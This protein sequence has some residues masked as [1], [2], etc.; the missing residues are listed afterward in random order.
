M[1]PPVIS[2]SLP[3]QLFCLMLVCLANLECRVCNAQSVDLSGDWKIRLDPTDVGKNERWFESVVGVDGRLPGIVTEAGLGN[4]LQLQPELTQKVLEHLHQK[5]SYIGSAWFSRRFEIED[6]E[7]FANAMLYLERVLWTSEVWING[8]YIGKGVSLSVPHRF[9]LGRHLKQGGNLI[10]VRV[11]NR[12][13]VDIGVLGH[14]YTQQ[15]QTI[16][17]GI[18]GR[19]EIQPSN[20]VG[21]ERF[22]ALPRL[23]EGNQ[24]RLGLRLKNDAQ[25]AVSKWIS[26]EVRETLSGQL[27]GGTKHRLEIS[28]GNSEIF[29]NERLRDIKAWSEHSPTLYQ[30]TCD[31]DGV[32]S[33]LITGF[34]DVRSEGRQIKINGRWSFMRGTLDCCL[35]PKTGYPPSKV[36]DWHRIFSTLNSYGINHVR[37][38]SWCPPDAAFSAADQLGLYLQVELPNWTSR[39]GKEPRVDRF[40]RSEGLRILAEY[41][42]H[43][44]FMFLSLGNELAGD[45]A[46][47]DQLVSDLRIVAPHLLFTSTSFSFTKRGKQPGPDDDYFITQQTPTGWVRGQRSLELHPPNTSFDYSVGLSSV[48]LPLIAHEVGQYC[49]FP[50]LNQIRKIDGN[51]MALGLQAIQRDLKS[52]G[53]G[54]LADKL[55][56]NSGKLA[57]IL[58]KEEIERALRTKELSGFQLLGLQD[59]LGQSTASVGLLDAFWESKGI[60]NSARFREFCSPTVPLLRMP[61]RCWT[62]GETFC[63]TI[64]IANFGA[65][66]L[67]NAEIEFR[68]RDGRS[69]VFQQ[70]FARRLKIGN[71]I[72]VGQVE[73]SLA[74]INVP[75]KLTAEVSIKNTDFHNRWEFWVYPKPASAKIDDSNGFVVCRGIGDR[76]QA[77]LNQDKNILLLIERRSVADP[78][79]GSFVPVFWS[80][81]HFP[82]QPPT[83]G[84][85]IQD[86]HPVFKFFPTDSH[87]NWQWWELLSKSTSVNTSGLG[88]DFRPIVEF[89]DKFNRN[90]TA[91]CL[92]ELRVGNSKV[93]VSTLDLESDPEHRIVAAQL[94]KSLVRYLDS[95]EFNPAF[96]MENKKFRALFN[97]H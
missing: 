70:E 66:E 42:H 12:P 47:L 76:F 21:V 64:E 25:R 40:L 27:V 83:L 54:P 91:S 59:F 26:L 51:L 81:L 9:A 65:R 92:F 1:T 58:Y 74:E 48:K 67:P 86:N 49:S 78:I 97:E 13:Y 55:A 71:G 79:D 69:V 75:V 6:L 33:S 37:F 19:I 96:E 30:I 15:T 72:Q 89:I 50:N 94:L 62:V 17:N 10:S 87:S 24:V 68:I 16:W 14:A 53:K 60:I 38:H 56:T 90:S 39:M 5:R 3:F 61:K 31:L 95:P 77:A 23:T 8:E 45:L 80:P 84:A 18:I 52:K 20:E 32:R 11:D 35:F 7:S 85:R 2:K 88:K 4:P 28:P 34:R 29:L 46:Y 41:S 44:S 36:S 57:A 82:N 73:Y 93:L 43:P 63:S 22:S